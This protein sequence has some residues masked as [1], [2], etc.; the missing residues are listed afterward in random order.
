MT[1]DQLYEDVIRT[2]VTAVL[3]PA[4]FRKTASSFHRRVGTCVQVVNCQVS[5][6]STPD[7]KVFYINVG[8]AFD[9]VCE[10]T[11]KPILDKPK[12]Y[13]CDDRGTRDRLGALLPELDED[14]QVGPDA[15]AESV[16]HRLRAA[17]TA[18]VAELDRVDGPAT[19]RTH[20]WFDRFRPKPENAQILYLLGDSAAARREVADLAKMFADRQNANRED[21][22]I[23]QLGLANLAESRPSAGT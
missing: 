8:L 11:K 9:G 23:E 19:Y 4:G 7:A 21:W 3:K 2:A 1:T 15:E 14:W 16:A 10:L 18:L 5:R 12:E 17:M 20:R 6:G 13:E 22:W